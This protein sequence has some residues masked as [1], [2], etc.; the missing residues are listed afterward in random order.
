MEPML[1]KASKAATE[2]FSPFVLSG[3]LLAIIA[4]AT[5]PT[6][7]VP[8]ALSLLFIVAIPLALSL[9]MHR[10]GRV[11]DRFIQ[12]RAQRTP[13]YAGTLLSFTAGALALNFVDTSSQVPL[14]LNLSVAMLLVVALVNLKIKAS[15]HALVAA[16][17]A[18]VFPLYIP[19]PTLGYA[20]GAGVWASTVYSRYYLRKHTV[21]ELALGTLFGVALAA[22]FLGLR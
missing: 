11:G 10:T 9:W 1:E 8:V 12:D 15:M 20:V 18:L 17:F 16:L 22:V 19:L 21:P 4:I 6:W 7:V 14:A 5:D 2:I 3:L 13:F